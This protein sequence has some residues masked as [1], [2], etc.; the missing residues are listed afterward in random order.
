[1]LLFRSI[2]HSQQLRNPKKEI[3]S[4]RTCNFLQES[5]PKEMS[6]T[7]SL[8]MALVWGSARV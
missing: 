8:V 5:E 4:E 6:R 2:R 1:M 7:A 3:L